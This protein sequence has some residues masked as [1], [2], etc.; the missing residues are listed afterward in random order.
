MLVVAIIVALFLYASFA[1]RNPR[2]EPEDEF[3]IEPVPTRT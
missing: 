2:P 3:P 1:G